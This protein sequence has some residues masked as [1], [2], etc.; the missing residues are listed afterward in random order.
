MLESAPIDEAGLKTRQHGARRSWISGRGGEIIL[1][2]A[3]FLLAM[4]ALAALALALRLP[5]LDRRPMHV[6]EAVQAW[7]A[8]EL[9]DSGFYRY[10]PVEFHGPTLYYMVQPILRMAGVAE[11]SQSE[12]W[13]YRLLTV[14]AGCALLGL[15]AA[16]GGGLGRTAAL[17]A[18]LLVAL[19]PAMVYFSRFFIQEMLLV[20]FTWGAVAAGWRWLKR[21]C[22]G[23]AVVFGLALGLM[24][25]TKETS[26]IALGA[27]GGALGL[28]WLLRGR[29]AISVPRAHGL[30]ILANAAAVSMLFYSSLLSHPAG[31]LDSILSIGHYFG[32]AGGEGSSGQHSQPW[33]Y[34]LKLLAWHRPVPRLW[35]SEGLVLV[36]ALAGMAAIGLSP[37]RRTGMAGFIAIFTLALTAIYSALPYK[38]PWL[39]LSFYFGWIMLAGVGAAAVLERTRPWA[40]RVALTALM[41]AGAG[42]LGMQAWRA[43]HT[44]LEAD[45]R[46]PYVYSQAGPDVERLGMRIGSLAEV[47]PEKHSMLVAV[48][49]QDI[50]PVPWYLRRLERVGYWTELPEGIEADV[51]IAAADRAEAVKDALGGDYLVEYY[52]L[53]SG[54]PIPLFIERSLW[55]RFI[56]RMER[57]ESGH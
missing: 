1:S 35:W 18:G 56:E 46:N 13:H 28:L 11:F 33:F 21:P 26:I 31:I 9:L 47:H 36:L 38:T 12:A 32:R 27:A 48:V 55:E 42:Q 6:D 10:N 49:G 2:R 30:V 43:N 54:V 57:I 16:L 39:M 22:L 8:G 20:L 51:V 52:G 34:Y 29:P 19:S 15:L 50:W 53:R 14:L 17:V 37:Q 5:G 41:L 7:K 40:L 45:P 4:L 23:W 25:A 44:W 24:H 3:L